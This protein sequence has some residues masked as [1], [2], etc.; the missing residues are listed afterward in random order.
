MKKFYMLCVVLLGLFSQS[1]MAAPVGWYQLNASWRD[2]QFSGQFH[3]DSASPYRITEITGTL[4]DLAQATVINKVWNLENAQP[5]SWVFVNNTN[6][7]DPGGHDAGF[8]LNLVDL[9]ATLTL[10]T[11]AGNGLFDWSGDFAYYNPS[12]LDDSPLL[13]FSIVDANAVPVPGTAA[14]MVAGLL[15]MLS[16]R[17]SKS[18]S[19]PRKA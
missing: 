12:Q 1:A 16:S 6:P 10:D 9:G 17:R 13:S 11:A 8:Y 14:L 4:V 15:G 18:R 5:E 3:Y 2:G 19:A 7:A